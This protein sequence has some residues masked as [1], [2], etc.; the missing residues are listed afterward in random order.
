MSSPSVCSSRRRKPSL[1]P[2][3]PRLPPTFIGI[4][5]K[6]AV[7]EF[8]PDPYLA[9]VINCAFWVFYGMPFVHPNS[10]LVLTINSVGLVFEVVYLAIFFTFAPQKGRK[11]VM[12]ALLVET[13]FFGVI[14][15]I[16][17][18]AWHGTEKR[19]L[20]VGILSDVFNIV[21]YISPL[22]IM[23]KVIKTKSV[24]YMPFWLS[25]AN[26]C[27]GL[28]WAIYALIH[29]FDLFVLISNG[30]GA[31]SGLVQLILY[32]FYCSC[33]PDTSDSDDDN[34]SKKPAEIQLPATD[35]AARV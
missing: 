30:L 1:L 24:K 10:I 27:N 8:K 26:F 3:L 11:K 14:V 19:S 12:L 16:T 4:I 17:M 15:L 23:A 5:K 13:I 25:F 2:S 18:L 29:P 22:T 32:T 34:T 35:G 21:M 31:L 7:E 6:K 33:K 20:I 9:T 28:C